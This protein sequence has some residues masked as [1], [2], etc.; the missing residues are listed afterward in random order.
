MVDDVGFAVMV[1]AVQLKKEGKPVTPSAVLTYRKGVSGKMSAVNAPANPAVVAKRID[2]SV[3]SAKSD[4]DLSTQKLKD[5][6]Q[7]L[8]VLEETGEWRGA[9]FGVTP[10]DSNNWFGVGFDD[11]DFQPE[12]LT[13][14]DL[15][16]GRFGGVEKL[17]EST[18][19]KIKEIQKYIRI[20]KDIAQRKA[21]RREQNVL[22]VED[23]SDEEYSELLSEAEYIKSLALDSDEYKELF[24]PAGDEYFVQHSGSSELKGGLLNPALSVGSTQINPVSGGDTRGVNNLVRSRIDSKVKEFETDLSEL[25]NLKKWAD[26]NLSGGTYIPTRGIFGSNSRS[27]SRNGYGRMDNDELVVSADRIAFLKEKVDKDI[28]GLNEKLTQGQYFLKKLD[29]ND[30]QHLSAYPAGKQV[31]TGGLGYFASQANSEIPEDVGVFP[32]QF[33]ENNGVSRV[34][35]DQRAA[36][37]WQATRRGTLW[38][39]SGKWNQEIT[40]GFAGMANTPGDER[41]I[42]GT[43]KPMFGVS[44]VVG[45]D[46]KKGLDQIAPALVARAIKLKKER[47]DIS[48]ESVLSRPLRTSI[49]GAM[50][51]GE[52]PKRPKYPRTPTYGVAI[53]KGDDLFASAE[54]WKEFKKIYGDREV[55]FLDYETTGLV[56]DEFGKATSNGAPVQ[57]GAVKW[58]D[59][60]VTD[61]FNVFI[62]P[63][64]KLGE[65]SRDNL[66]DRDGNPLTDEWLSGQPSISDAHR[67]LAE[68]AG[69]DAIMGVQNASFDKNVLEDALKA[70]GIEW[71]PSGYIDTK[72][73]SSMVLPRWTPEKPDGPAKMGSEGVKRPSNG[74]KEITEYLGVELGTK[75][76]TADADAEATAEVMQKIIDGAIQN[77]WS[78]RIFSKSTR[79]AHIDKVNQ[80]HLEE[81]KEFKIARDAFL[82]EVERLATKRD[83]GSAKNTISGKMAS[84]R[85][86]D[87]IVDSGPKE[88]S[89]GRNESGVVKIASVK[90]QSEKFGKTAEEQTKFFKNKYSLEMEIDDV[91][92]EGSSYEAAHFSSLQALDDIL[93]NIDT[94]TLFGDRASDIRFRL[95]RDFTST[96]DGD[97]LGFVN[98][99]PD[100]G[101]IEMEIPVGRINKES[102]AMA[103]SLILDTKLRGQALA[104]LKQ[105][106][107]NRISGVHELFMQFEN[108]NKLARTQANELKIKA[109][110]EEMARRLAYGV[111]VH[112]MAHVLDLLASG[113]STDGSNKFST[114]L[115]KDFGQLPSVSKYGSTNNAEKFAE[116]FTAWWLFG[117]NQN[118][119]IVPQFRGGSSGELYDFEGSEKIREVSSKIVKPIFSRLGTSIK[120]EKQESIGLKKIP[121]L[122]QLYAI[123]STMKGK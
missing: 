69:P 50:S 59:G 121:P 53:G 3:Q 35:R 45:S 36:D 58:K 31:S 5:L 23:I 29:E 75:H 85:S 108:N 56:F 122:V 70:S 106:I 19:G 11:P 74:L 72:E 46:R 34:V 37:N 57:I 96:E 67:Q 103:E 22:D 2:G 95:R 1:R 6:E 76:H 14:E 94:K 33:Q 123:L 105:Q 102:N 24:G 47:K 97:L 79:Q 77:G 100:S 104:A 12:N 82:A 41:Q 43:A 65:W 101:I 39:V 7:A 52:S 51:A 61:R 8:K 48:P 30:G 88:L 62:N 110:Q 98:A 87:E 40:S 99:E 71:T 4:I 116:A 44:Q 80:K 28:A 92:D 91:F 66:K 27:L 55:V 17:K 93:S 15:A 20:Q 78:D 54:S 18:A 83:D 73:I 117:Q 68:F 25:M 111:M 84:V 89:F 81:I 16:S 49:S 10:Y 114:N 118:V 112:E 26:A 9:E 38:L 120:S 60:K 113:T 119:E 21:I 64:E 42:L 90:E 86:L 63:G 109:Q 13:A 107:G 32:T 115:E